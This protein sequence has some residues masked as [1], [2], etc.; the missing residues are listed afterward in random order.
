MKTAVKIVLWTGG[1]LL[2]AAVSGLFY[3]VR[4]GE[5]V[6]VTQ[7]GKPIGD[8][9]DDPGLHFK[10]PF[11][12]EVNRI[13]K[14]ILEWDGPANEMTTRDKVYI[15]VDT[16]ARWRIVDLEKYF[17]RLRDE[18]S[19]LSR[20]DDILGSETM[21]AVARHD[22]IEIIRTDKD[23]KPSPEAAAMTGAEEGMPGAK[24]GELRK[25][26]EGRLAVEKQ[27]LLGAQ[28]K[29]SAFGI[30]L[31]DVRF[32]RLDYDSAVLE[33]I[34]ERMISERRQIAER[35]R[36]EGE[37]MAARINGDREKELR[38]IES[39]AYKKVQE[40]RG[41]ADAKATETYAKAFNQSKEAAD[42]YGFVKTMETYE[43]AVPDGTMLILSTDSELWRYLRSATPAPTA[44]STAVPEAP[45]P[46]P[47][48]PATPTAGPNPP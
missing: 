19:A 29:L 46:P 4:M 7:F 24:P 32:K 5:Q 2:L 3:T 33:K 39:E 10:T 42:F 27:I 34:F 36:S 22:L 12:Q 31:L 25:I 15:Q 43:K 17:V 16:F 1:L 48:T 35:F 38:R 9:V 28:P 26:N 23:R 21:S 18:R 45:T 6:I 30:E 13:E 8:P 20:L 14:R 11:I 41:L 40:I 37:A 44:A 47:A